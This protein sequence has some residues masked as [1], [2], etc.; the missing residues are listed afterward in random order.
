[1]LTGSYQR[2]PTFK[3]KQQSVKV[4]LI[5]FGCK[6][7]PIVIAKPIEI[8]RTKLPVKAQEMGAYLGIVAPAASQA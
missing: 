3:H 5:A 7:Q 8:V 6:C 2:W 1:L 4:K